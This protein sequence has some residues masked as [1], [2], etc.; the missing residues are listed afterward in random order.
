MTRRLRAALLLG[1]AA[2]L[3]ATIAHAGSLTIN[4]RQG[5]VDLVAQDVDR[6]EVLVALA[7]KSGADVSGAQWATGRLTLR[8]EQED[9]GSAL[10]MLAGD[11]SYA[12]VE[13]LPRRRGERSRWQLA[14]A[15]PGGTVMPDTAQQQ[16]A[17]S[18]LIR[19]PR[20]GQTN[21]QVTTGKGYTT[22]VR[23]DAQPVS[24]L[25]LPE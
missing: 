19:D 2:S 15:P 12:L 17:T 9:V 21:V 7:R 20:T 11:S 23:P 5:L 14:I 24:V 16:L 6:A 13:L 3:G 22:T 1:A 8:L 25:V 18:V 4:V 10:R